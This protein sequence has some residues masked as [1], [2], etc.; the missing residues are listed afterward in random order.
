MALV[1]ST[2]IVYLVELANPGHGSEVIRVDSRSWW[3]SKYVLE[4]L[5]R[6]D[7]DDKRF[8]CNFFSIITELSVRKHASIEILPAKMS[9]LLT[10]SSR[11]NFPIIH[12]S[13]FIDYNT[14]V[15]LQHYFAVLIKISLLQRKTKRKII[16]VINQNGH[17]QER[18]DH[19]RPR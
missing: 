18:K 14:E 15:V 6:D 12:L 17:C 2:L 3:L 13:K 10:F 8:P 1:S 16:K 11:F 19:S 4:A 7:E 9:Q 5:C